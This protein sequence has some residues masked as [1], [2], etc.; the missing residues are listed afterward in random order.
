MKAEAHRMTAVI[1]LAQRREVL[2]GSFLTK[3]LARSNSDIDK[4]DGLQCI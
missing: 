3:L 4:L 2:I 1:A